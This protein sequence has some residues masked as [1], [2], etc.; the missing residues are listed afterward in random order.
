MV[1]TC[2]NEECG[3]SRKSCYCCSKLFMLFEKNGDEKAQKN[4]HFWGLK[5]QN[6]VSKR[7]NELFIFYLL[8]NQVIINQKMRSENCRISCSIR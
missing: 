2:E 1:I 7:Q 8:E 3:C 4:Y 6:E 5:R